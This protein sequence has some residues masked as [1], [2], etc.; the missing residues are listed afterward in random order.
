M[1]GE[2]GEALIFISFFQGDVGKAPV[3]S[4]G[5]SR[6]RWGSGAVF[7]MNGLG[8]IEVFFGVEPLVIFDVV[9]RQHQQRIDHI[10][11]ELLSV[12]VGEH[13]R[14]A[15]YQE[16]EAYECEWWNADFGVIGVS[17]LFGHGV[18]LLEN[19]V[20]RVFCRHSILYYI[21]SEHDQ[22]QEPGEARSK[23]G[24]GMIYFVNTA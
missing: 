4:L 11:G 7:L 12:K 2:A 6:V 16:E 21:R 9:V 10:R 23:S 18:F 8:V 14:G 17:G 5:D 22:E 3:Q 24:D 1:L 20:I 13:G 15:E 19:R